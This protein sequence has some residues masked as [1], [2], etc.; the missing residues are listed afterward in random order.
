[1][2]SSLKNKEYAEQELSVSAVNEPEVA[3][4]IKEMRQIR[5][6]SELREWLLHTPTWSDKEYNNYLEGRSH[7]N[8]LGQ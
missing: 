3:Y 8:R 4:E 5:S 6:K 1:M 2:K 7:I